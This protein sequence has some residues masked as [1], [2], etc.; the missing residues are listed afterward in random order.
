LTYGNY[1]GDNGFVAMRHFWTHNFFSS[2]KEVKRFLNPLL[3]DSSEA[4]SANWRD[5][6]P[7]VHAGAAQLPP[8][9]P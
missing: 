7:S 9:F 4:A 8:V 3:R 5:L 2:L 6:K 1:W